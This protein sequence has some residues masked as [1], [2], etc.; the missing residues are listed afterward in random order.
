MIETQKLTEQTYGKCGGVLISDE[1][2][3]TAAHCVTH[4][5]ELNVRLGNSNAD[6]PLGVRRKNYRLAKDA[7]HIYPG[8]YPIYAWNDIGL[9][10]K[11]IFVV[12]IVI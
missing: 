11:I 10:L 7:I 5:R 6:D 3:I 4:T 12:N 2:V 1:W 8:Y 9:H